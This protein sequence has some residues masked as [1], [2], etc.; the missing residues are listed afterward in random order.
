MSSKTER[1]AF[2]ERQLDFDIGIVYGPDGLTKHPA[3]LAGLPH[4]LCDTPEKRER[5]RQRRAERPRPAPP[6]DG[7]S[8]R[9]RN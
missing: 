7:R 9:L 2:F 8:T 4:W 1:E 6:A 3:D 5:I